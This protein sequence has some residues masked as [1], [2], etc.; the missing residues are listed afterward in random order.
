MRDVDQNVKTNTQ[1]RAADVTG[2]TRVVHV[3]TQGGAV[4][5]VWLFILSDTY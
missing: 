2:V 4:S 3:T 1:W 5:S